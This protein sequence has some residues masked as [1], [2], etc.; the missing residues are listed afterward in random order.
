MT[1]FLISVV[2][3]SAALAI[4]SGTAAGVD[5]PRVE[6]RRTAGPGAELPDIH[7]GE[8]VPLQV[9]VSLPTGY[10]ATPPQPV[11]EQ[12]EL[13]LR[14]R[15]EP[16]GSAR[17]GGGMNQVFSFELIPLQLGEVTFSGLKVPWRQAEGQEGESVSES[18][19]FTVLATIQDPAAATAADIRGPALIPVPSRLPWWGLGLFLLLLAIGLWFW[20]RRR[21]SRPEEMVSPAAVDPFGGLGPAAWALAALDTLERD[22]V[23][24]HVGTVAFHVRVA[25]ILRRY[26]GGRFL[27]PTLER[28]TFE[29]LSD[30]K[31]QMGH[32]A[33]PRSRLQDLLTVCDMV[34]F[35][36]LQ[37][38]TEASLELLDGSRLFVEETRPALPVQGEVASS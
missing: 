2:V 16:Q 12:D 3:C 11:D 15:G 30:A 28:T 34:K 32:L 35:A 19:T 24:A 6:L 22:E 10:H 38:Q 37:P 5:L 36:R 33:G 27:V 7:L 20:W 25:E 9:T 26:L 4:G 23:L 29:L 13:A 31:K 18:L 17:P 21:R 1:R 14:P 8:P